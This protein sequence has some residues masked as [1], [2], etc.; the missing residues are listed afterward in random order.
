MLKKG[1]DLESIKDIFA[2]RIIFDVPY[3]YEEGFGPFP[4]N[5]PQ[6]VLEREYSVCWEAYSIIT[7]HYEQIKFKNYISNPKPNGYQS[8]HVTVLAPGNIPVEI[9]IRTTRM[10]EIAE[11]GDAAHWMYKEQGSNKIN[12]DE[13]FR[14][15][16][17]LTEEDKAE[18]VHKNINEIYVFTPDMHLIN[19]PKEATVLDFAY[20]IHSR[21]GEQCTGARVAHIDDAN[22]F[23]VVSY[24]EKLENG[25]IV[26]ILTS[27]TQKP[28]DEWLDIVRTL[29]A[30]KKIK[31]YLKLQKLEPNIEAAKEMLDRK[32]TRWGYSL[33]HPIVAKI[34]KELG[35]NETYLFYNDIALGKVDLTKL[36]NLI[37]EIEIKEQRTYVQ[38]PKKVITHTD[39]SD[40]VLVAIF[41]NN[42]AKILFVSRA[43]CCNPQVGD[44]IQV[45]LSPRS[46]TVHKESCPELA[47]IRQTNPERVFPAAWVKPHKK[48]DVN[49][50]AREHTVF[51][52]IV[53]G[54]LAGIDEVQE[55]LKQIVKE[56]K[57]PLKRLLVRQGR[58]KT[59]RV[60]LILQGKISKKI[61]SQLLDQLGALDYVIQIRERKYNPNI[62]A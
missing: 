57:L 29:H 62:K 13:V 28:T 27:P 60:F 51:L 35:Y 37:Q 36:K 2:L 4:Q 25:W 17:E 1:Q 30:R 23:R 58:G 15:L 55:E 46:K 56:N 42:S 18:E 47:K 16:R 33:T 8:L 53:D 3:D 41:E 40:K 34:M 44:K 45:Y 19:L 22:H 24:K 21:I 61:K 50:L 14:V 5:V 26:K 52:L 54:L 12:R 38:P 20:A 32:L 59:L 49:E 11:K 39:Q 48:L 31:S 43:K 10:D 6:E 7:N 9:Q